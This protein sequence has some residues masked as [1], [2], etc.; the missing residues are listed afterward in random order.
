MEAPPGR[1]SVPATQVIKLEGLKGDKGDSGKNGNDGQKADLKL[2]TCE[3]LWVHYR[4]VAVPQDG[5][6]SPAQEK[7]AASGTGAAAA[8]NANPGVQPPR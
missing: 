7:T 8:T 5:P 6:D 1:S 2:A 3:I 4:C